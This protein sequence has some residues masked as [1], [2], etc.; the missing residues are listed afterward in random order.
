MALPI[1]GVHEPPEDQAV[2]DTDEEARPDPERPLV[3]IKDSLPERGGGPLSASW[4]RVEM[5]SIQTMPIAMNVH[6]MR[7][8]VT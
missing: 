5:P 4:R 3:D 7:R 2:P 1:G 8:A 6:S